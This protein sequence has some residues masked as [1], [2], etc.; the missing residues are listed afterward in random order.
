MLP[1]KLYY[2]LENS[3]GITTA[4]TSVESH[5]LINFSDSLYNSRYN[6]IATGSTTFDVS[7]K[8]V[9]ER[10]SYASS[11]TSSLKY[12]TTSP[13]A[14]GGI[15]KADIN[16]SGFGYKRLPNFSGVDNTSGTGA[17][18]IPSSKSIGNA[19]QVRIINEGFEYSSDK[20]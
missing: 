11:E 20:T 13:T 14:I 15:H 10:L 7:L 1:S 6:I 19:N 4:D 16:F 8:R 18:V 3:G 2:N 17:Y 5:S 12:T 9:P